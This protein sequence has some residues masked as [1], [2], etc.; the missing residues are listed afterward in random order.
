MC[1]AH[2][3]QYPQV[4]DN[5]YSCDKRQMIQYWQD[6]HWLYLT[7][8]DG[9]KIAAFRFEFNEDLST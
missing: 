9:R 7:K 2:D 8:C 5:K 3:S 1:Q 6:A 4:T